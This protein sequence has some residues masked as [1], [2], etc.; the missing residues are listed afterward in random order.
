M[1]DQ[2]CML[3]LQWALP[4]LRLRWP[5]FRK[6]RGQVCKRIAGRIHELGVAGLHAYRDHL[7]RHHDEWPALDN[8]CR[9]TISRFF[10][11]EAV[12]RVLEGAVLPA[13]AER[14]RSRRGQMLSCWCAGCASGEEPYSLAILWRLALQARFPGLGI[15]IVATDADEA[16]LT[17]ARKGSYRASS[18]REL[19]AAWRTQAF[20]ISRSNYIL[21]DPFREA[22]RF[23]RRDLRSGHPGGPFDIVLCRN[24]AFT[25]FDEDLQ[26]EVLMSIAGSLVPEGALVIGTHEKLPVDAEGFAPWMAGSCI[27]RKTEQVAGHELKEN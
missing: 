17:R 16:L 10:R 18:L 12:F 22:V 23:M 26:R 6:V 20:E 13:F 7:E 8:L 15:S 14:V 11:D 1:T 19:P 2:D 3:F 4:R 5:G 9:I 24:L 21:K 27:Y 25:Y